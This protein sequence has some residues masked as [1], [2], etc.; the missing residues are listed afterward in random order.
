MGQAGGCGNTHDK[1]ARPSGRAAIL[2]FCG[3]RR[4]MPPPTH[5]SAAE[6][7]STEV[8]M[9][10][11]YGFVG[12]AATLTHAVLAFSLI[13]VGDMQALFAHTIG[14][15]AGY[16]VSAFGHARYTFR[17]ERDRIGARRR[18]F[19][20]CCAALV[21]SQGALVVSTGVLGLGAL[22]AQTLA[23]G[24]SI[25]VSYIAS[26]IWA[27]TPQEALHPRQTDPAGRL[28]VI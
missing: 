15:L 1:T 20:V 12:V 25:L 26:R 21:L 24:V 8:A 19:A 7:M 13:L 14:F 22:V 17:M 27:F 2:P 6:D 28:K 4:T 18:F 10:A 11:R 5:D 3:R 9:M 23:I 16:I